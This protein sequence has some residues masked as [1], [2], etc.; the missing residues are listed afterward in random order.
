MFM[1]SLRE[2]GSRPQIRSEGKASRGSKSKTGKMTFTTIRPFP[3]SPWQAQ[4]PPFKGI[5]KHLKKL[6]SAGCSETFRCK[7]RDIPRNEAYVTYVAVT[8][9]ERNAAD[10]CLWTVC[11]KPAQDLGSGP[12]ARRHADRKRSQENSH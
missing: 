5:R 9:D 7:A 8:R 12:R 3:E 11:A 10:E 6:F 4:C 1:D 2:A